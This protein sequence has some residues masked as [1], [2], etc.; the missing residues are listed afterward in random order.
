MDA[1]LVEH[2]VIAIAIQLGLSPLIGM[3]S[4]GWVS[5]AIFLGREIAQHEYHL[6]IDRGWEWGHKLPVKWYEG[7]IHHW[8][9]DSVLDVLA[10]VLACSLVALTVK[11]I[12]K[13]KV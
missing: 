1:T 8:S 6:G 11:C 7:L 2:F 10:P 13:A 4:A 12:R 5:C 9:L 3:V